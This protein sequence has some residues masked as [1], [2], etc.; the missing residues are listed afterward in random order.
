MDCRKK[1]KK[2][3]AELDQSV[4]FPCALLSEW[5]SENCYTGEEF[6]PMKDYEFH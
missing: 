5:K 2:T 4:Y 6:W 1:K 3:P